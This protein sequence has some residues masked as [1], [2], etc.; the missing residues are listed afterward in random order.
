MDE[1]IF[2]WSG[3]ALMGTWDAEDLRAFMVRV[4]EI[5]ISELLNALMPDG[6]A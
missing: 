2:D 5:H 1:F 3:M 4:E 6:A